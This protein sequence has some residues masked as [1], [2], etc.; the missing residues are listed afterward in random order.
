MHWP[1]FNL[2][3]VAIVVGLGLLVLVGEEQPENRP[4]MN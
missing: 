3:D 1:S 4:D 2:A